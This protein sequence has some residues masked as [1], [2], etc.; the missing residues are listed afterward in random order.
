M[1]Q[2]TLLKVETVVARHASSNGTEGPIRA[3]NLVD[4]D[5]LGLSACLEVKVHGLLLSG[6]SVA[7]VVERKA[8]LW[9]LFRTFHQDAVEPCT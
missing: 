4:L 5:V 1:G 9:H 7:T 2:V 8:N 6:V 3:K